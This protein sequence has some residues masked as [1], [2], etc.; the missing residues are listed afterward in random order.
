MDRGS[1]FWRTTKTEKKRK[2]NEGCVRVVLVME[3]GKN[4]DVDVKDASA[5]NGTEESRA[6][7]CMMGLAAGDKNGG[8]LRMAM[9]LAESLIERNGFEEE[10]VFETLYD[11][12]LGKDSH[13]PCFDTGTTFLKVMT[14]HKKGMARTEAAQKCLESAGV[15]GAHRVAP[16]SCFKK[17]DDV[18]TIALE[19]CSLTHVNQEAVCCAQLVS[20]VCRLLIEGIETDIKKCAK[21]ALG[22]LEKNASQ[23][24]RKAVEK[25]SQIMSS[26]GY[27]PEVLA[28]ALY[29]LVEAKSFDDALLPSLG[30]AGSA[31]YCPVLV[32]MIAGAKFGRNINQ[33]HFRHISSNSVFRRYEKTALALSFSW[34]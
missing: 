26:G 5:S 24:I 16:I 6:F 8:P 11:W 21:I 9:L 22:R 20:L 31:N 34:K 14:L 18:E 19:Q 13:G 3:E 2:L 7:G 32:G 28:A 29:F 25:P 4:V 27:A 17:I 12:Y 10:K 33:S 23:K 1:R 30:Y 15:N